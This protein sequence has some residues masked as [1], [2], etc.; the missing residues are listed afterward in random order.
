MLPYLAAY[1][2]EK[3][4]SLMEELASVQIGN[5]QAP[6]K[7]AR[8]VSNSQLD[9]DYVRRELFALRGLVSSLNPARIIGIRGSKVLK[10]LNDPAVATKVRESTRVAQKWGI[11]GKSEKTCQWLPRP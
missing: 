3:L 9:P 8:L 2:D 11:T 6:C 10:Y 5:L 7:M 1:D 4:S